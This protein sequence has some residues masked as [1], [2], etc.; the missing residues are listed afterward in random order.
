MLSEDLQ[1][2]LS[3]L[4]IQKKDLWVLYEGTCYGNALLLTPR[5]LRPVLTN[6]GAV[7]L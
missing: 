6:H 5:K 4:T 2:L 3:L 1:F 7:A